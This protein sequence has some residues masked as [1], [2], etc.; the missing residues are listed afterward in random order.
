MS[1]H[2]LEVATLVTLAVIGEERC[3][4]EGQVDFLELAHPEVNAVEESV[5]ESEAAEVCHSG[6]SKRVARLPAGS[7]FHPSVP[8]FLLQHHD[9]I[10]YSFPSSGIS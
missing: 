9:Y 5:I 2:S 4:S 8:P 10:F 3:L 1:S 7:P 6:A